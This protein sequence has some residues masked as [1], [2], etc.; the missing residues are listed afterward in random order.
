[1]AKKQS[2][3]DDTVVIE[4]K[5]VKTAV[6][7][8]HTALGT[9]RTPTGGW[10]LAKILFN[11]ETGDVGELEKIGEGEDRIVVTERFKI[12]AIENKIVG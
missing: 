10:F 4:T 7:L 5:P 11:P 8:T 1:M 6:Q 3:E 12:A 2:N 9:F